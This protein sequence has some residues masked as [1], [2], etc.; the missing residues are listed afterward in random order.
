MTCDKEL[1]ALNQAK[2][3][4]QTSQLQCENLG[5]VGSRAY[6]NC[7]TG[8]GPEHAAVSKAQTAYDACLAAAT[9]T[10]LRESVGYVT[11]LRVHEPGSGFG[12][13]S[14]NWFDADV[15][16]RLDSTDSE[17]K[18]FGFQLRDENVSVR[19]GMLAVLREAITHNLQV[20]TDYNQLMTP[21]NQNSFVI[22]VAILANLPARDPFDDVRVN[23]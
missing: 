6:I 2:T 18:A 1:A 17:G 14:T 22:R 13:G 20:I 8:L 10:E 3:A 9:A 11:F 23:G 7:I 19:E 21:P 16:F 12:G 5:P 15:V 4:L